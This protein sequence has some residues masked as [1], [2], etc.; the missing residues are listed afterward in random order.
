MT[1]AFMGVL[2]D[3]LPLEKGK[4]DPMVEEA[5]MSRVYGGIH[6]RFDCDAGRDIGRAAAQL[7]LRGSLK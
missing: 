3:A 2:S 4:L 1:A 6:F 5:G 7:A